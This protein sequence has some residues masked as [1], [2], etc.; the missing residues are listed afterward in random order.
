MNGTAVTAIRPFAEQMGMQ[1]RITKV[2]IIPH[3]VKVCDTFCSKMLA[4]LIV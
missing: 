2:I 4:D 1:E 3:I